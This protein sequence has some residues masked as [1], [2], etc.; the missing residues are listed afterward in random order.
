MTLARI[1]LTPPDEQA[2]EIPDLVEEEL[3][4]GRGG[5]FGTR[6]CLT[7]VPIVTNTHL[8]VPKPQP[9]VSNTHPGCI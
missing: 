4:R 3:G 1:C 2:P 7:L 5:V 6:M 9:S 8:G